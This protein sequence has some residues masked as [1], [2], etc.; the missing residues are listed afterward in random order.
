MKPDVR[1]RW[2]WLSLA[3]ALTACTASS[4]VAEP[5]PPVLVTTLPLATAID[6]PA[7]T[8]VPPSPSPS[9]APTST[10]APTST[11]AAAAVTEPAILTPTATITPEV[12]LPTVMKNWALAVYE[13]PITLLSYGWEQALRPSDP[14]A[15]YYP[16][17]S[18]ELGAVGPPAPRTYTAVILENSFTR[19]TVLPYLGGR[20]LRWE[21]RLTGQK[22]TYENPVIM[23]VNANWGY[24][25]WWL[26]TGGV[27]W[28]FPVDEHGLNEY[29]PWDYQ[30]LSGADWRGV[31]VWHTDWRTGMLIE[32]TLRLYGGDNSLVI[33]PRITNPTGEAKQMMFWINAMLTLSGNNAPSSALRFW[34][35]TDQMIVHSTGDDQLPGPRGAI[36]WP[37]Y[38]GRN[39]SQYSTWQ[40]YLGIFATQAQGAMGAYDESSDLGVVR[41][42]PPT[43]PQGVKLFCL[44]ELPS[45]IFT[46]DES[47][48]FELWGGYNRSFFA[49]DYV[50]L[51]AGQTLTWEERWYSVHGIGGLAWAN[52]ELAAAFKQ[53]AQ[54]VSVGLYAPRPLEVDLVVKQN[55][56]VQGVFPARVGPDAPFRQ[57]IAGSG[58]GWVLE[59]WKDGARLVE[60][61][62]Y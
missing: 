17:H 10:L 39:F 27:E 52:A 56:V 1:F 49:E 48:Y 2:L 15:P 4:G 5:P 47:R 44:G 35:P 38:N 43:I 33:T 58:G 31:R 3:L 50:S 13:T 24:R 21:D 40:R 60:I 54:G 9:P 32:I 18:L 57:L 59:I 55:D 8:A 26:A 22:L 16:Y 36:T 45:D 42:Y 51:P 37:I 6:T 14:G 7:A 61:A 20:I 62:P 34:A 25:G 28:A 46:I 11:P 41:T 12:Y 30:L 19:I 53:T 23:P 29:L